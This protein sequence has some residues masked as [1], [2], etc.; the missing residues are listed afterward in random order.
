[1]LLGEALVVQ[2]EPAE[3]GCVTRIT[4]HPAMLHTPAA[5]LWM[6]N[7]FCFIRLWL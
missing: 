1:M 3:G 4:G 7:Y 2:P 6:C 5:V